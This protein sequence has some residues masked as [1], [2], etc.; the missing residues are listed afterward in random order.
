MVLLKNEASTLCRIAMKICHVVP[1]YLPGILPGCSKYVRDISKELAKW[2]HHL[3]VLTSNAVTGRGW[4][5]PLFGKYSS[6]K[7]EMIN[8]VRVKRLKTQWQM[9]STNYLLNRAFGRFFPSSIRNISALLSA[10]PY[11][12]NLKKEFENGKYEVIH[13][14][15]FP[16][17]LVSLVWKA[18]KALGKP[19]VCTPLIHFEDPNHRNPLLWKALKDAA[20]VVACSNYEKERMTRMGIHPSKIHLIPMG[21]NLDEWGD[22]DGERFRKKYGL[23]GKRLLLFV[24]TK[25]YNKGATHLLEAMGKIGRH[26]QDVMLVSLGLTT[27]EWKKKKIAL[28]ETHLLDLGYV[29]EEEK[30]DAF[31]ACDLFAMPS[32]YDSFGIVYLE[33]WRCGKP[34]IGAKVGA[35]PEVIEEGKDGLLV[36]FGEVD[37]LASAIISLLNNPDLCREM[38]E[39][40]R[41]KV[42]DKFNWQKNIGKIEEVFK[43]AKVEWR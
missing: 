6:K 22:S 5:D 20:A 18:C 2:G 8:G 39:A 34:V 3:T 40:G 28:H 41:K 24:G 37:Q 30:K 4:V 33:A 42:I 16:F 17:A 19:F 13:V 31:D 38:G 12:P 14:T 29:S 15:A 25:N 27:E 23:T 7:E 11:L 43:G 26:M 35:I 32:R 36:E 21:I 1:I 9:T 10:G